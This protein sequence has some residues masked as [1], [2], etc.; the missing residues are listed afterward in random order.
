MSNSN[1][2]ADKILNEFRRWQKEE[3]NNQDII[4]RANQRVE[5][6]TALSRYKNI[7][8]YNW[9]DEEGGYWYWLLTAPEKDIL[10]W[11]TYIDQYYGEYYKENE[12]EH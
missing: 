9:E 1:N 12:N 11:V 5:A 2:N 8:L 3:E 10:K 6:S 7:L 4:L